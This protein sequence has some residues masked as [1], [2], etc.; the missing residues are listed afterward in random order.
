MA[1]EAEEQGGIHDSFMHPTSTPVDGWW[2]APKA[3]AGCALSLFVG[4]HARSRRS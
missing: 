1:A 4:H 2:C 3:A